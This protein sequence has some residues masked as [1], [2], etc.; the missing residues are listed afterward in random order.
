MANLGLVGYNK[1]FLYAVVGEPGSTHDARLL[2]ESS[3]FHKILKGDVLPDRDI[4]LGDFGYVSLATVG[5]SAFP[6]FSWLIKGY[7]EI[8]HD[9]QQRYSNK[10]LCGARVVTEN[11]YGI[12]KRRWRILYK[13][14]E[15]R[16]FN[17]RYVI[18]GC[19]AL[20]NLCI[21]LADPS[22]PRWKLEVQEF[23]LIRKQLLR[24]DIKES[25][26]NRMTISNWLWMDHS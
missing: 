6:Q 10:R 15:C 24:E 26:L 20:H 9:M 2:K 8:T 13:K 12:L 11:A 18:M 16:L 5:D 22:G 1:R 14:T 7:N 3:I 17:L 19:I 25:A 23:A 4:S 21:G